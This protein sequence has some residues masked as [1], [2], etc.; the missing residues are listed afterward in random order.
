MDTSISTVSSEH[1]RFNGVTTLLQ[2]K[3]LKD[4]SNFGRY[5]AKSGSAFPP[6]DEIGTTYLM[7]VWGLKNQDLSRCHRTDHKCMG[8][9]VW[10]DSFHLNSA[11][12]QQALLV[13]FGFATLF[14]CSFVRLF[15]CS[16]VRLFVCSFVRLFVCSF[17]RV[18]VYSFS[19]SIGVSVSLPL[20]L[21]PSLPPSFPP[22]LPLS[23]SLS[24]CIWTRVCVLA[25]MFEEVYLIVY[26]DIKDNPYVMLV[27][28]DLKDNP[29]VMLVIR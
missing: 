25:C 7:L 24:L 12:A 18:Y 26:R 13:C 11:V 14:V 8:D 20:S 2:I 5:L 22:P 23:I 10:D 27:I 6:R 4:S 29:Y 3:F 17:V 28:R 16:F 9:T 21:C 15:V 1:R 19:Q